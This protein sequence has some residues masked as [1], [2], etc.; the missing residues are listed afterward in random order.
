MESSE[1]AYVFT[2]SLLNSFT[3]YTKHYTLNKNKK[4]YAFSKKMYIFAYCKVWRRAETLCGHR[5]DDCETKN[6]KKH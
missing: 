1:Q 5:Y 2:P 4:H 3:P 6:L